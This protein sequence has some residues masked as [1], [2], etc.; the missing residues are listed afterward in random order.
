MNLFYLVPEARGTTLG[1]KLHQYVVALLRRAG[2]RSA[3]L[4][5]SP[6]NA[7]AVSYYVKHGWKDLGPR[8]GHELVNTME[9]VV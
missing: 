6:T 7:R 4:S 8:P 9:L 5:V 2:L 1:D 3:Q